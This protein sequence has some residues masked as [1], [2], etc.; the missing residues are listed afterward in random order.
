MKRQA[1]RDARMKRVLTDDRL[2]TDI[3]LTRDDILGP[4]R[5]FWSGWDARRA[6]WK[7]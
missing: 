6:I 2:L 1:A 5:S 3:G 4:V 7:L